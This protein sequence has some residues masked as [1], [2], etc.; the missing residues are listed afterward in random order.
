MAGGYESNER[1]IALV[2]GAA[3]GIGKAIAER[4]AAAQFRVLAADLD[5]EQLALNQPN[6]DKEQLPITGRKL[7]VSD[8]HGVRQLFEDSARIDVVVNN[9]GIG[10]PLISFDA[11]TKADIMRIFEVNVI[12]TFIVGQEAARR[13]VAGGRIINISSRGYLGGAGAA[14]YVASKAAVVGLTRAMA[15]ELRWSGIAVNAIA[16]GMI[17]TRALG[18]FDDKMRERLEALEPTGAAASPAVI[19]D[20][21][22][23]LAGA[24]AR[25]LSGEVLHVDGGKSLGIPRF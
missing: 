21:V 7:D 19:A 18:L 4:L 22:H 16:P 8:R 15:I 3:H 1:Q 9:A 11:L 23:F 25:F 10:S 5:A 12:G 20:V 14:H 13:M 17:K 6:W 2:T 24:S